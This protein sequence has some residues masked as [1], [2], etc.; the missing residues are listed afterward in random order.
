MQANYPVPAGNTPRDNY[1]S[2]EYHIVIVHPEQ[3]NS[4][5]LLLLP[6]FA[7]GGG[8]QHAA[9]WKNKAT[10]KGGV[11]WGGGGTEV[12]AVAVECDRPLKE[13]SGDWVQ[14]PPGGP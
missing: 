13:T 2:I 12:K 10:V 8:G 1:R 3:P 4:S 9:L 7:R 6:P 11:G 5:T 14:G